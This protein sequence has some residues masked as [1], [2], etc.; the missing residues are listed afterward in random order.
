MG[1]DVMEGTWDVI[2][3]N[4][5]SGPLGPCL[6]IRGVSGMLSNCR[7]RK[8][9]MQACL[10]GN[11]KIDGRKRRGSP[12]EIQRFDTGLRL[13]PGAHLGLIG[14]WTR[15]EH[16]W[17]LRNTRRIYTNKQIWPLQREKERGAKQIPWSQTMLSRA[18]G[19]FTLGFVLSTFV[20]T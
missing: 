5:K 11:S 1:W 4:W 12:V 19:S 15:A 17:R 18:L 10:D 7:L 2:G 9:T 8:Q 6:D 3:P 14:G 16:L 20:I 13:G